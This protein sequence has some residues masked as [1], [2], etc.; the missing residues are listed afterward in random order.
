STIADGTQA[1]FTYSWD[2]GDGGSSTIKDP[3]HNYVGTGPFNV[4]LIVTSNNGCTNNAVKVLNTIYAEP[5]A[6]FT[7]TAEVCLGTSISFTD[8]SSAAGSTVSQWA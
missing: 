6:A 8:Q 5:Q 7:A 1:S 3:L 4:G 2:F